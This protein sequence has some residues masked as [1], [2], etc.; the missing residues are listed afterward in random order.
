MVVFIEFIKIGLRG[1]LVNVILKV[2]VIFKCFNENIEVKGIV[3]VFFIL[4]I[5]FNKIFLYN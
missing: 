1:Y 4:A 3:I 5:K 2:L